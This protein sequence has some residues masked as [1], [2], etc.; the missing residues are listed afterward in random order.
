[1]NYQTLIA[2]KA[3]RIKQVAGDQPVSEFDSR[4]AHEFDAAIWG[5]RVAY[6][7]GGTANAH[8]VFTIYLVLGLGSA[9]SATL[10]ETWYFLY[11]NLVRQIGAILIVLFD[12]ITLGFFSQSF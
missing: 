11:G 2:T 8:T 5:P 12:L 3:S 6:I 10:I 4:R 9:G 1:M 7:G